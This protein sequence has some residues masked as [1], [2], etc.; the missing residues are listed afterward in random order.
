MEPPPVSVRLLTEPGIGKSV[1]EAPAPVPPGA[2]P[3]PPQATSSRLPTTTSI[4]KA[5]FFTSH[6][7]L[8]M[9]RLCG[10]INTDSGPR[11][12]RGQ[13]VSEEPSMPADAVVPRSSHDL[14]QNPPH[15]DRGG[16]DQPSR[17]LAEDL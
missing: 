15:I 6:S 8:S 5:C 1:L 14:T 12:H 3:S 13:P 4:N 7:P 9:V 11:L 17:L 2:A 16:F 10:Q